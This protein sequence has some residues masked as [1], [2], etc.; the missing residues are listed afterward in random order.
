[1][2]QKL[3]RQDCVPCRKGGDPLPDEEI[4]KLLGELPHWRLVEE[5]GEKKL[6]RSYPF[7]NFRQ[8]L[9]LTGRI[10]ERAEEIQH[11][12]VLV[13]EWGKLTVTWWTHHLGGLHMNDFI[14]AARSDEE[15]EALRN[16]AGGK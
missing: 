10:G 13:T 11:H 16:A 6:R 2:A 14:M 9:E 15:F 5:E 3:A 4:H 12:P 8:A 7:K 1:M